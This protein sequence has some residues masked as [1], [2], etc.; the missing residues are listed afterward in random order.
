[1]LVELYFPLWNIDRNIV[2]LGH[3]RVDFFSVMRINFAEGK[4]TKGKRR[5]VNNSSINILIGFSFS[6]SAANNLS[7]VASWWMKH[8][9]TLNAVHIFFEILKCSKTP[10]KAIECI[11]AL[12]FIVH[13]SIVSF[14]LHTFC[15]FLFR[16]NNLVTQSEYLNEGK[17]VVYNSGVFRLIW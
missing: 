4:K 5:K 16:A 13:I 9:R 6:M 10:F 15:Y 12:L 14:F 1:M 8:L 17:I 3:Q 11:M 2:N 7:I